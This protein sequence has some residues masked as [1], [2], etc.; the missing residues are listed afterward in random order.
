MVGQLD[1][2]CGTPGLSAG[3][4]PP[5]TQTQPGPGDMVVQLEVG[6]GGT[7]GLFAGS[8]PPF[9]QTQ[10]GP[11]WIDGSL[12]S[13]SRCLRR[14][15]ATRRSR[16]SNRRRV[17]SWCTHPRSSTAAAEPPFTQVQPGPGET[18]GQPEDGGGGFVGL[19]GG[20]HP[21]FTQIQPGP[22]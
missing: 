12:N 14:A 4:Q 22:G 7:A 3:S 11:G 2:D 21:P 13:E 1:A 9:T 20:S 6:G 8:Q 16:R 5:F 10:P 17:K 19:L 18:V 15:A